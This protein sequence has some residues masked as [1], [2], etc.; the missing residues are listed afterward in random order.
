MNSAFFGEKR[1]TQRDKIALVK[2]IVVS[3]D[4]YGKNFC[5]V[6]IYMYIDSKTH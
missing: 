2:K 4:F 1:G 6:H 5:N 3:E